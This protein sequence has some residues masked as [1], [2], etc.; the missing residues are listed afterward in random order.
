LSAAR[1]ALGWLA[2]A[3]VGCGGPVADTT[4]SLDTDPG[5]CDYPAGAVR[6]MTLGEVLTPYSWPKAIHGDGRIEALDLGLVPCAADPDIDW[7]PFDVLL[8]VSLPAW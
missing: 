8:F 2:A 6:T 7:S 1:S 3:L 4:G 5:A